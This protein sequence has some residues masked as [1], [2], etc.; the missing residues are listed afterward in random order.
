MAHWTPLILIATLGLTTPV[1]AAD[2]TPAKPATETTAP[3]ETPTIEAAQAAIDTTDY[4]AAAR[5]LAELAGTDPTNPDVWNLFGFASRKMGRMGEASEAYAEA[6]RLKPDHLGALEYQ[7]EMFVDLKHPE[8]AAKNL[9]TLKKLC[10]D[11]EQA[12]DLQAYIDAN[13]AS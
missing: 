4:A 9:A 10:G 1:L 7:G 6:L 11:C 13:P 3:A 8:D 12:I 5:I 2:T